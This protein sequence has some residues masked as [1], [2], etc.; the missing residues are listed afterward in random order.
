MNTLQS[1][2]AKI[3]NYTPLY[4]RGILFLTFLGHG[5]TSLGLSHHGYEL[6]HRI[7]ES[8]NFF[9]WNANTFLL[10]QGWWDIFLA[11]AILSGIAPRVLLPVALGYLCVIAGV[12]YIYYHSRTGSWFGIGE[13]ARRFAWIFYAIFLILYNHKGEQRFLLLRI[14]IS[15]AFLSHGFA[16]LGF[17][18]MRGGQ[19]ELAAQIFPDEV[20]KTLVFYSGFSDVTLGLLL[21]IGIFS[22][23]AATIGSCWLVI[24]VLLSFMLGIPEGLFRSAFFLSCLYVA[25][26]TRCHT[27]LWG[28]GIAQKGMEPVIA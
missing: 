19:I 16:S 23:V 3:T 26:D 25:L 12:A 10:M 5:L 17:F 8:T 15:F 27:T 1:L 20:A 28:N 2:Q 7:F 14:G 4:F 9:H 13:I 18:G 21:F 22:R 11:V 24:V 6:H